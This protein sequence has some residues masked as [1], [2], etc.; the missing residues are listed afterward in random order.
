MA[1]RFRVKGRG[2]INIPRVVAKITGTVL[3]LYVGGT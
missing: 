3:A 1:R 2:K